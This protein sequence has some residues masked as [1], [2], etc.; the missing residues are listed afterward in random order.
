MDSSI[1]P[2]STILM[3]YTI[4]GILLVMAGI[5]VIILGYGKEKKALKLAGIVITAIGFQVLAVIGALALYLKFI[6]SLTQ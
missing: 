6:I 5:I 4:P 3:V 1:D 2:L